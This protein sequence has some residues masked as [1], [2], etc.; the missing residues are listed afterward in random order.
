[1]S[2][3]SQVDEENGSKMD[4]HN[5]ATVM[6]PNILKDKN[7]V[8]GMDENSFLGIEAVYSMLEYNDQ[9][10]EVCT[11]LRLPA[12]N[13]VAKANA[14]PQVPEDLQSILNDSSLFNN[15]S[16]IT[17]KEIL[18]RYGDIGRSP[19]QRPKIT[20]PSNANATNEPLPNSRE[21]NTTNGSNPAAHAAAPVITHIDTDPYQANV[22][23]KES[24]V[25]HVQNPSHSNHDQNTPPQ[26]YHDFKD[27]D[28]PYHRRQ[29]SSDSQ[30][31]HGSA[32]RTRHRHSGWGKQGIQ[33]P[34]PMGVTGAG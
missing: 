19:A 18:K 23:Q 27:P 12:L 30:A 14:T 20:D 13:T 2:S 32:G 16:D 7:A 33:G 6:A 17:T 11:D 34:G 29:G 8:P 21:S 24:S 5:L 3:F 22:W 10:C 25:R 26:G 28:S 31:S 15:S 4:T 9:M 1:M